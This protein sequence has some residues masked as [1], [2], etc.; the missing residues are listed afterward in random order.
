MI[1]LPAARPCWDAEWFTEELVLPPE[2]V[3]PI[4]VVLHSRESKGS[5]RS[6]IRRRYAGVPAGRQEV[7]AIDNC[8]I[9]QPREAEGGAG[10]L[11]GEF[12]AHWHLP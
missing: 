2:F 3:P 11:N 10:Y 1:K 4:A 5:T 8:A 7:A 9:I 12:H 6:R